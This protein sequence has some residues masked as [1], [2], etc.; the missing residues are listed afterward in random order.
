MR[1]VRQVPVSFPVALPRRGRHRAWRFA[2]AL[3]LALAMV[4]CGDD[5]SAPSGGPNAAVQPDAAPPTAAPPNAAPPSAVPPTDAPPTDGPPSSSPPGAAPG[6]PD[7]PGGFTAVVSFG[8]S[9]SDAGTYAPA[10]SVTANG[11][12]PF[13]GGRFTT[14][15]EG[16]RVW[17]EELAAGLGIP[18]TQAVIG[19]AG[20]STPCPAAVMDPALADSCTLYGQGGARVT[21]AE[22]IGRAGGALTEPMKAQ[23]D[24]HLTRFGGFEPTDLVFVYG[25][26]NDVFVAF[27]AFSAE[28]QA[29]AE[30]IAT[31]TTT[32]QQAEQRQAAA[33]ATAQA[34]MQTA[35]GELVAI[36]R[37]DIL[38]RGARYVAVMNL[39]DSANTPF[40]A[41]LPA[42]V[43]PALSGLVA[44]FNASLQ[45][46]LDGLPVLTVD[47]HA[48]TARSL[49][50]P[51]AYGFT[52]VTNP[53]CDAQKI[54]TL[55]SGAVT[56]GSSLFCNSSVG[57]PIYALV[58]GATDTTY[59]FADGVHPSV[60]G[61]AVFAR[62]VRQVLE[63]AGW[64]VPAAVA[65][66]TGG[67]G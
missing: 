52:N 4:A 21:S 30:G 5:V 39:P 1:Q 18:A 22:G 42:A 15:R 32:A 8:D 38:A 56:D 59:L 2:G 61:H 43:R 41:G 33:F 11:Q 58:D 27:G 50:D 62:E 63:Q 29:I 57:A 23:V 55:T 40:G 66:G 6:V 53:A 3:G 9:L 44:A 37:D 10:T 67:A 16:A 24:R 49:A 35:A 28:L 64:V 51:A 20:Q 48:I 34:Q 14:N 19:F 47:A 45:Q 25:G 31:G 46:G 36:V 60:G 12:P 65:V 54:A 26:N 7:S 13:L 17:V